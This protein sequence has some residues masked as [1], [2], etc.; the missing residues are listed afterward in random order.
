M[1]LFLAACGGKKGAFRIGIDPTWSPLNFGA[2]QPYVNGFTEELLLEIARYSG[3][4]F[5]RVSAN[6]DTLLEGLEKGKYEA[7]LTSLPPYNFNEARYE[8]SK[9]FLDLGP[10]LIVSQ[11]FSGTKLTDLEVVG[12]V[13]GDPARLLVQKYPE[14]VV[15]TYAS[16]P[17]L[18]NA[19]IA[20]EIDGALHSQIPTLNYVH[21]LY[22]GQLK[23]VGN[24]M[25]D[26]GLHLVVR[27]DKQPAL[28][29]HFDASLKSLKRKKRVQALLK[30][31]QLSM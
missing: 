29:K 18:L 4:E 3:M 10:V 21:D 26:A 8:F 7:V 13:T 12:L 6:R 19:I 2:E 17:F 22:V 14:L 9:N 31:W 28:L 11:N 15:R 23:I 20:G 5:E 27:K 1:A 24:P 25:G 30:K 16:L